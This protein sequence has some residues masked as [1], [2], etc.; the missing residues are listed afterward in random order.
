MGY[1]TRQKIEK[2]QRDV[3]LLK[4]EARAVISVG[5]GDV[6]VTWNDPFRLNVIAIIGEGWID[7]VHCPEALLCEVGISVVRP[8]VTAQL[9]NGTRQVGEANRSRLRSR[10]PYATLTEEQYLLVTPTLFGVIQEMADA[11]IARRIQNPDKP[12]TKWTAVPMVAKGK[13]RKIVSE[14]RERKIETGARFSIHRSDEFLVNDVYAAEL[15]Y[16]RNVQ[17]GIRKA[18]K[19]IR[20]YLKKF[21]GNDNGVPKAAQNHF[22]EELLEISAFPGYL[23]ME[24]VQRLRIEAVKRLRGVDESYYVYE[25]KKMFGC[26]EEPTEERRRAT[27][28]LPHARKRLQG[29]RLRLT[30][31]HANPSIIVFEVF[32][33]PAWRQYRPIPIGEQDGVGHD[34]E[35]VPF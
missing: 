18:I 9:P 20:R 35:E 6:S 30:Y 1:T 27:A 26:I 23:W 7:G 13:K 29:M 8:Y 11:M 16:N 15:F 10:K 28:S 31:K 32:A 2:I 5:V 12:F 22:K 33:S 21:K 25:L 19:L 3:V 34:D 17:E 4:K 14:N 24:A